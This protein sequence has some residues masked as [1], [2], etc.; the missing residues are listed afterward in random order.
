MENKF[1]GSFEVVK[2]RRG[3]K[4]SLGRLSKKV[5]IRKKMR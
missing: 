3:N 5:K 2:N 1:L 4:K